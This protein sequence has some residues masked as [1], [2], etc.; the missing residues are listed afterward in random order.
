MSSRA[1]S[2]AGS[3]DAEMSGVVA[4]ISNTAVA[5]RSASR[6]AA[7]CAINASGAAPA[8]QLRVIIAISA[9]ASLARRSG[10][11]TDS[12]Y[13]SATISRRIYDDVDRTM[14]L[15]SPL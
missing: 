14:A 11:V 3:V 6:A 7:L 8:S 10:A 13:R 12:S 4:D 5:S 1:S 2:A 9:W 15:L